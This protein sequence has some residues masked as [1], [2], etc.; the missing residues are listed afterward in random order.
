MQA[1]LISSINKK[2]LTTKE[3]IALR[4]IFN[5]NNAVYKFIKENLSIDEVVSLSADQLKALSFRQT[6]DILIKLNNYESYEQQSIEV[7]EWCENHQIKIVSFFDQVYPTSL[8]E[9][10][11]PSCLIFCAGNTDLLGHKNS[12]AVVGARQCSE[13]GEKITRGIA[14]FFSSNNINVISGL[15]LGIDTFA[16]EESL[17]SNGYTTAVLIDLMK[18][19]PSQNKELAKKIIANYGLIIS[20]NIPGTLPEKY[21]YVARN[22]LQVALSKGIFI[23][24]AKLGSGTNTTAEF[25]SS[26]NKKIFCPDITGIDE[27]P[28]ISGLNDL[29]RQL[30]AEGA[31]RFTKKT[32]SQILEFLNSDSSSY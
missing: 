3:L 14:K 7:M 23:I 29:P 25:A 13:Y 31:E 17:N 1:D 20:E 28:I 26:Q 4:I 32:Y 5:S 11:N 16:H 15:A 18:I 22:R 27:Y 8:K 21:H 30:I 19:S 9:I 12:I 10:L 2:I 24:E 6:E